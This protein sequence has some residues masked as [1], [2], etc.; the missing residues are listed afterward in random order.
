MKAALE[1]DVLACF[2]KAPNELSPCFISAQIG[3]A[4]ELGTVKAA[5][6]LKLSTIAG[7]AARLGCRLFLRFSCRIG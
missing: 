5:G 7:L 1:V 6:W 4:L 3:Y 2:Y